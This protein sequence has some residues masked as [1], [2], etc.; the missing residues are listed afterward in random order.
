MNFLEKDLEE[1]IYTADA[2]DLQERGLFLYKGVKKF[3]QLRIGKYG[4]ADLVTF[5]R[6]YEEYFKNGDVEYSSIPVITVYELKKDNINVS[7]FLQAVGYVKGIKQ[8]LEKRR[9]KREYIINIVLIGRNIDKTS[10]FSYLSDLIPQSDSIN[11]INF[12][13]CYTYNYKIN[14]LNFKKECGYKLIEEGF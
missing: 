11:E 7:T 13:E 2:E 14:G 4:I 9:V 8:Y 3:R 12:L 6:H 1:I 10:S 5:Q